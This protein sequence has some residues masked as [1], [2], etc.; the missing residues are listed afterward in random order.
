MKI[1]VQN[2]DPDSTLLEHVCIMQNEWWQ[3]CQDPFAANKPVKGELDLMH[4]QL[5]WP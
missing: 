2:V 4:L 1:Y 5:N 3:F